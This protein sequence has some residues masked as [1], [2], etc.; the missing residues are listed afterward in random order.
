L[1]FLFFLL[2]LKLSNYSLSSHVT[3]PAVTGHRCCPCHC[4]PCCCLFCPRPCCRRSP[5]LLSPL[6]LSPLLALSL[7]FPPTPLLL[8]F[9]VAAVNA[10]SVLTL[11]DRMLY[12]V[13]MILSK[14]SYFL[15]LL[16]IF[17]L[18][19]YSNCNGGISF[20]LQ[21]SNFGLDV[22]ELKKP[23]ASRILRIAMKKG[24]F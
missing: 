18:I 13:R 15:P 24:G 6:L 14:W 19:I 8:T 5:L 7:S 20:D 22:D 3:G 17:I 16:L 10:F 4:W 2:P 12:F 21:L 23:S 1:R 9:A 11:L